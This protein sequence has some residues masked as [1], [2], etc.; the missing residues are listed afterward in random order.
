[1]SDPHLPLA[2]FPAWDEIRFK[3]LLSLLSWTL[4]RRH[5]HKAAPLARIMEDIRQFHPE[6]MALTGDLT[7]LGLRS[8]FRRARDW[9]EEQALPPTLLVPGN[10][11]ALIRQNATGKAALWA[12]WLKTDAAF[13]SLLV[14]NHIALIGVNTAVPT[15]PFFASGRMGAMQGER[16]RTLL[17]KTGQDGLC[18]VVLLHHPPV[19]KLVS[20][21]K[22]MDDLHLFQ[23][24]LQETGAELVLHGHSHRATLACIPRTDIPVIGTTSASH[25]AGDADT[26][27]GWNAIAVTPQVEHWDITV[28]RRELGPDG[29]MRDGVTRSFTPHRLSPS[30]RL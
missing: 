28:L 29:T 15:R 16:L 11:D 18:R 25:K 21:R 12:E 23:S 19:A 17:H 6:L 30:M 3:R 1:M 7:N 22:G 2:E 13:P 4:K 20:R 14:K 8:E 10:H 9:L 24:I 27:A 5:L 26:T